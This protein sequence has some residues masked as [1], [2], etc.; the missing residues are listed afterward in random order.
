MKRSLLERV[1]GRLDH[2]RRNAAAYRHW[3]AALGADPLFDLENVRKGLVDRPTS[4][5]TEAE[6]DAIAARIVA[7]YHSAMRDPLADRACYRPSN[8]WLPIFRSNLGPLIAAL[9]GRDPVAVRQQ[10]DGFFR[11]S[12]S[13]GLVG[14][15]IDMRK[16]FFD[17]PPSRRALTRLLIDMLYRFRHL[18]ER[19]PGVQP[20]DLRMADVG[21]PYGLVVDGAFLRNGVDYQYY[22]AHRVAGLLPPQGRGVVAEL[23]GG[24]GGFAYF[25]NR[26]RPDALSYVNLDLPEILAISSYQLLNLF[27]ERRVLLHG[28]VARI[29]SGVVQQYD[30]ALLP[31]FCVE[32]LHDDSVDVAFN[33]YSLAEMDEATI[34]NYTAHM[35]R[36]TRGSIFHVNH[37]SRALVGADRFVFDPA[38]FVQVERNQALWN[39]GRDL[40]CDEY[41]FLYQ[42][43]GAG[44]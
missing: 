13:V 1:K 2:M 39:L 17:G 43:R 28:E 21:N 4:T 19:L 11:S 42:R 33:S 23:G 5:G 6:R 12:I 10:L 16:A 15:A 27:P 38:R 37:V 35:S 20:G 32:H 3:S 24:T 9:Q 41:E 25:L 29:D 7:A 44:D 34:A 14:L 36:V 22:Y 31:S 18:Q 26:L 40:E 30:L 8:E